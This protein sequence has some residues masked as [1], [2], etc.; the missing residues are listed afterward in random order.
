MK[1]S[2]WS[3]RNLFVQG[4]GCRTAVYSD[5]LEA[6]RRESSTNS[7]AHNCCPAQG[8]HGCGCCSRRHQSYPAR[9]VSIRRLLMFASFSAFYHW[10]HSHSALTCALLRLMCGGVLYLPTPSV[11]YWFSVARRAFSHPISAA[12]CQK[13]SHLASSPNLLFFLSCS[14]GTGPPPVTPIKMM[15]SSSKTLPGWGSRAKRKREEG[16]TSTFYRNEPECGWC[17]KGLCDG[18]IHALDWPSA[19]LILFVF[20]FLIFPAK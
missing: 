16:S 5:A 12:H 11:W 2:W 14:L 13:K 8:G 6:S 18:S 1:L 10:L 17:A 3:E 15:I 9:R 7:H 19:S 4:P 20:S